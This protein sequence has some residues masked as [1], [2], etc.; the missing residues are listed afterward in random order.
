M[1]ALTLAFL[2]HLAARRRDYADARR[3]LD[4]SQALLLELREDDL[5]A[6]DRLRPMLTVALV[7]NVL[8]QVQLSQGDN[9]AAAQVFSD[10]VAV[11]RR[12]RD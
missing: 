3:F 7:D 9:D 11:A 2:G 12:A 10:G 6:Y 8:G 5:T 4:Q 1:N